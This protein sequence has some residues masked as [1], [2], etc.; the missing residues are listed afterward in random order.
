[1]GLIKDSFIWSPAKIAL[2]VRCNCLSSDRNPLWKTHRLKGP[3]EATQSTALK[4]SCL[5]TERN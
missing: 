3:K 1:M 2:N 4:H 5:T